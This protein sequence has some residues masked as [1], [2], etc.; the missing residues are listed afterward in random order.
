[1]QGIYARL[2]RFPRRKRCALQV[3]PPARARLHH[4]LFFGGW[5]AIGLPAVFVSAWF[6]WL[7]PPFAILVYISAR[8][9]VC[10]NCGVNVWRRPN[11]GWGPWTGT[12]CESCGVDLDDDRWDS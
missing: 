10:P 7:V 2:N 1:M 12:R 9:N 3:K 4:L 5:A 11:Y 6:L 8:R